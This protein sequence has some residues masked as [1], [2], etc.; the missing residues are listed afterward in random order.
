MAYNFRSINDVPVAGSLASGDKVIL[1]SGGI[2][3][4]IDASKLGGSGG[5]GTIY[6]E[7]EFATD[8]YTSNIISVYADESH[9]NMLTYDQAKEKFKSG[10]VLFGTAFDMI[11]VVTPLALIYNE[12]TKTFTMMAC[13]EDIMPFNV[14]CADSIID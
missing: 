1:N 7:M 14:L 4:Q 11:T 8:A 13:F 6:A 3:K 9:S 2:A 12:G 5:G 10:A